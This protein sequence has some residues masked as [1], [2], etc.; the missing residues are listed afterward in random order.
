MAQKWRNTKPNITT[1]RSH[2]KRIF[3][4]MLMAIPRDH[5]ASSTGRC[6]PSEN[7]SERYAFLMGACG[8]SGFGAL[9][10]I[11]RTLLS[12][13][14]ICMPESAH[15]FRQSSDEFVE[16]GGL[17]VL[18]EGLRLDVHGFGFGFALL[19]DDL[20]FGFALRPNGRGAPL[21]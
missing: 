8:G 15:N 5:W 16:H 7:G 1:T 2:V 6:G 19:E 13:S 20:R 10:P 17:V 12:S 3:S 9:S 21:G 14:D 11:S 4:F 18:L